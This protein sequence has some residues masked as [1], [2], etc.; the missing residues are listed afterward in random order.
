MVCVSATHDAVY[1]GS[2]AIFPGLNGIPPLEIF[3]ASVRY[4]L[5]IVTST[6]ACALPFILVASLRFHFTSDSANNDWG[7][8]FYASAT[9][10]PHALTF[11]HMPGIGG[12]MW[13]DRGE[14]ALVTRF[15]QWEDAPREEQAR[16][17]AMMRALVCGFGDAAVTRCELRRD[18]IMCSRWALDLLVRSAVGVSEAAAAAAAAADARRRA[19]LHAASLIISACRRVRV[20]LTHRQNITVLPLIPPRCRRLTVAVQV[21]C[22][23]AFSH[24]CLHA[25]V[26]L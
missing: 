24:W 19:R 12:R 5:R 14:K 2:R 25:F 23:R 18:A 26:V 3:G 21:S 13:D 16:V 22:P 17:N 20:S 7:F 8:L 1:R 6:Y 4:I 11:P 10:G 15:K 9:W